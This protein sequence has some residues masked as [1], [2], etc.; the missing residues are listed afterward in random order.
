MQLHCTHNA[1]KRKVTAK[2]KFRAG[3]WSRRLWT[4]LQPKM[5]HSVILRSY[6]REKPTRTEAHT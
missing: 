2:E 4:L 6:E 1:T 5:V 3:N